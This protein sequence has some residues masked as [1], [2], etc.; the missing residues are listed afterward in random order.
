MLLKLSEADIKLLKELNE[1][2]NQLSLLAWVPAETRELALNIRV[3]VATQGL[4]WMSALS[5]STGK[6]Q[7][8]SNAPVNQL[9]TKV[10]Q[11]QQP[12]V[13]VLNSANTAATN[14]TDELA[15][16]EEASKV[17]SG[18]E[19]P[20]AIHPPGDDTK[21]LSV[22]S[23]TNAHG[24]QLNTSSHGSTIDST[25]VDIV[26]HESKTDV[27]VNLGDNYCSSELDTKLGN[28]EPEAKLGS[29]SLEAKLGSS[30]VEAKLGSYEQAL[31]EL[32]DHL[33]AVKGHAL[34][35]LRKCIDR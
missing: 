11:L 16:Q 4:V 15:K 31:V 30:G 25:Q 17:V 6:A 28:S 8:S 1:P 3:A 24:E 33:I 32:S 7:S 5:Q 27:V 9:G 34:I 26:S 20:V 2:L 19:I 35:E 13:Q 14:H 12:P 22:S 18:T 23:E 10:K 29:S 21:C